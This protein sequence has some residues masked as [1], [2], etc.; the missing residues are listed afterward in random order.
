MEKEIYELKMCFMTDEEYTSRFIELLK[1]VP[2]LQE[3]KSNIQRFISGLQI[4]FKD[5][6]V[7]DE[8]R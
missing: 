4:A 5:G 3:E 8:P 2:Y 6:I 1:Y 7:F